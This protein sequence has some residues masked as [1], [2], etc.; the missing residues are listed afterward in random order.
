MNKGIKIILYIILTL[1][2]ILG[3][4][5]LIKII[6]SLKNT[7]NALNYVWY[8]KLYCGQN[9]CPAKIIDMDPQSNNVSLEWNTNVAKYCANLIIRIEEAGLSKTTPLYP[10][11]IKLLSELYNI[12]TDPV[13]GAIFLDNDTIW[14]VLRGTQ[15]P[16]EWTQDITY[17]QENISNTQTSLKFLKNLNT[18]P[19]VHKG[20]TDAYNNFRE[21]VINT[22]KNN[23][24][25][26]IVICGHSLGAGISTII[27]ADLINEG[28]NSDNNYTTVIYNFASPRVGNT[29]FCKLISENIPLYR[30]VNTSDLV[31]T[32][33]PSVSPNFIDNSTPYIYTH[34]GE[35][36]YFTD[37]RFSVLNNHMMDSYRNGLDLL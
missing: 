33:P 23:S 32:L 31:P 8:N 17:G 4:H 22:L 34:C 11:D 35:A 15:T 9:R 21:K 6:K 29:D 1:L 18:Y 10:K 12:P 27:G 30:I 28:Y 5:K 25:K 2:L 3:L 16:K 37:N 36:K 20:F 26:K 7:K 13:F 19:L 24:F 14:I